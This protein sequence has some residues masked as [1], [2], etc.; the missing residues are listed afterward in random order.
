MGDPIQDLQAALREGHDRVHMIHRN[1]WPKLWAAIDRIA[2][3][4]FP[5]DYLI[6]ADRSLRLASGD[7]SWRLRPTTA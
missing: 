1:E 5:N 4:E 6:T 7:L 3:L 2:D